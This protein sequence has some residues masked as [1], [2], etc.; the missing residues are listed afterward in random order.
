MKAPTIKLKVVAK[1]KPS[2]IDL[3]LCASSFED[4]CFSTAA[5]LKTII[6]NSDGIKS[7]VY[8]NS[9]EHPSIVSNSKRLKRILG[10]SCKLYALNTELPMANASILNESLELALKTGK[11]SNILVDTTTF[12][13]ETLLVLIRLLYFKKDRFTKLFISYVGAVNYSIQEQ[14]DTKKWLSHGISAIRSIVGYPGRNSPAKK[15]HLLVMFGFESDRTELLINHLEFDVV[16]VGLGSE[17][18]SICKSN[19]VINKTRY[20]DL[21]KSFDKINK[22]NFSLID[23]LKAKRS[24]LKQ[25]NKFKDCNCVIA[26]MN[27]KISA[28]GAALAGID[29]PKIQIIYAKPTEYNVSGY[30]SPGKEVF[31][32]QLI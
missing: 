28:I 31:I 21:T 4:R 15:N 12:T 24:I 23:P 17:K 25:A 19:F 3:F 16:S 11:V 13:H 7:I 8:F 29:N 20:D 27:N 10:P 18:E 1:E 30:S 22:F 6:R 9:N 5:S 26:P 2:K 32:H 14:E